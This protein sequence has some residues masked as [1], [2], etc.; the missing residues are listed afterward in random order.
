[1]EQFICEKCGSTILIRPRDTRVVCPSCACEYPMIRARYMEYKKRKA[2]VDVKGAVQVD[3]PFVQEYLAYARRAREKED[4]EESEKYYKM[5]EQKDPD[6]IEAIFYSAYCKAKSSLDDADVYKRAAKFKVLQNCISMVAKH[7][8]RERREEN[9]QA[10]L[11]MGK[12]LGELVCSDFVFNKW[13]NGYGEVVKTDEYET[14]SMFDDILYA[15]DATVNKIKKVDNQPF[16]YKAAID[17]Y[18]QIEPN[19]RFYYLES[20]IAEKKAG[21]KA[22]RQKEL[23][24]YWSIPEL[25][26]EKDALLKECKVLSEKVKCMEAEIDSLPEV[27]TVLQIEAK[28]EALSKEHSELNFSL[29]TVK[30]KRMLQEQIDALTSEDLKEA[31]ANMAS[32]IVNIQQQIDAAKARIAKIRA[33]FIA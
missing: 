17:C 33:R 19:G 12:D 14:Y 13:T 27:K 24:A 1:M 16:L 8:K 2:A 31:K 30:R 15:F 11:S 4:W 9:E 18:T 22:L 23:D 29:F 5:I 3:N 32:A 21:L 6:N 7:Y 28:I 20:L 10:I 26:E 25:A